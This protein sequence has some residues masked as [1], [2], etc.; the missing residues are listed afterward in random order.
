VSNDNDGAD[1][2]GTATEI[3]VTNSQVAYNE[4]NGIES[5]SQ[6]TKIVIEGCSC[7]HNG[8]DGVAHGGADCTVSHTSLDDNGRYGAMLGA[9]N[10]VTGCHVCNNVD[11]GVHIGT[12][13]DVS[14]TGN[15]VLANGGHGIYSN[16][17]D[18][19]ITA[20]RC[21]G[22]TSIGVRLDTLSQR[23]LVVSNN[24]RDNTGGSGTNGGTQNSI[25]GN[26]T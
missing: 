20:N 10:T 15:I 4:L 24:L 25:A 11:N 5:G 3:N 2:S 12:V 22:N 23:N 9:T 21:S 26:M 7:S 8:Q 18:G 13:D 14:V 19:I 6:N 1:I 17:D 16:G